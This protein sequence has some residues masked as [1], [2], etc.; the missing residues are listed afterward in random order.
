MVVTAE[1]ISTVTSPLSVLE[2]AATDAPDTGVVAIA[3]TIFRS[4]GRNLGAGH[5]RPPR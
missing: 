4:M 2:I 5:S 3:S 1:V